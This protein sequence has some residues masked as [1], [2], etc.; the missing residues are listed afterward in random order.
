MWRA[1]HL[2]SNDKGGS[3]RRKGL[4]NARRR[5]SRLRAPR[6]SDRRSLQQSALAGLEARVL[7]V[8]DV[9]APAP[10]NQAVFAV[11]GA[12]RAHGVADLHCPGRIVFHGTGRLLPRIV[13]ANRKSA[14]VF[15][16]SG[17]KP[18]R[19]FLLSAS[20]AVN[21]RAP[22]PTAPCICFARAERTACAGSAETRQNARRPVGLAKPAVSSGA[23][24]IVERSHLGIRG[25][26]GSGRRVP[27]PER[28][29]R[30]ANFLAAPSQA[31]A[32]RGVAV[33]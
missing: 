13:A 3:R 26:R 1:A 25:V 12:Q 33:R 17:Q 10:A 22:T 15:K 21:V 4:S 16:I 8:D 24:T 11:T 2:P 28:N 30:P 14:I 29:F 18:W 7:L 32:K 20:S 19:R 23:R 9:D 6:H 31:R 27:N 5:G